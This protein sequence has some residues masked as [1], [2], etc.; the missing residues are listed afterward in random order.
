MIGRE[1]FG[2]PSRSAARCAQEH[3]TKNVNSHYLFSFRWPVFLGLLLGALA[4][5]ALAREECYLY[6][7]Y[8]YQRMGGNSRLGPYPSSS[9]CRSVNSGSFGDNGRC[10]CDTIAEPPPPR[11]NES[12]G[13]REDSYTRSPDYG[14]G[15]AQRQQEEQRRQAEEQQ[16]QA[17]ARRQQE[18]QQQFDADKQ[19]ALQSLKGVT[20]GGELSLKGAD[21]IKDTSTNFFGLKGGV[22]DTGIK[23]VKPEK[24]ARDVST[25]WKQLHCSAEIAGYAIAAAR[26]GDMNEVRYLA[27]EATRALNGAALGV[28]C[29]PA[30]PP[31]KLHGN[32]KTPDKA[33]VASVLNGIMVQAKRIDAA[34]RKLAALKAQEQDAQA[35]VEALKKAKNPPAASPPSSKEDKPKDRGPD[36][37]AIAKAYAEQQAYQAQEKK[38]IDE[39]IKKQKENESAMA[40]ALAALHASQKLINEQNAQK[41]ADL[42][43]LNRYED[44]LNQ[45]SGNPAA[46]Q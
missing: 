38:R 4:T 21:T 25:A 45:L 20:P 41:Q 28:Q 39:V 30:P 11:T 18:Q 6:T 13:R 23:N 27:D 40:E 3:P 42:N 44:K 29:A 43:T 37:A 10:Q 2:R 1:N 5:P 7:P 46:G 15:E 17:A 32:R 14:D 34:D 19:K 26:K 8:A 36:D 16:R 12:R 22:G 24:H 31:P 33:T 35:R 9:S